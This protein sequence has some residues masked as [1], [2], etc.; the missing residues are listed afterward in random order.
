MLPR[1]LLKEHAILIAW[2]AKLVDLILFL[3][4][5]VLAYY[6]KFQHLYL[7]YFY[8]ITLLFATILIIPVFS[9]FGI[10]QPLRGRSLVKHFVTLYGAIVSVMLLLVAFMFITKTTIE[11]SR[12]WFC[13]WIINVVVLLSIF[14]LCLRF[15]LHKMRSYGWNQKRVLIIGAGEIGQNLIE[16]TKNALW[17]GFKVI[18]T[19]DDIPTKFK[20]YLDALNIDEIWLT[21]PLTA[22]KKIKNIITNL[23]DSMVHIRYFPNLVDLN[24]LDYS[25][26]EIFGFSVL[27][28][29]S[30]PMIGINRLVK[31]LED[32]ILALVIL[33]LTSPL[34]LITVCLVKLSSKGPIFYRQERMSWN[35]TNFNMLKFRSMPINSETKSGAVWAHKADN[36][37]TSIGAFLR[38]TSLDEL[39][40]FINVLRG[41]MSIV[42]P[43]PERPVFVE[44]FK[45]QIPNYMKKHLV[46]AGITGWAQ[47]NG[48]RGDTSLE[49]RIEHDLYYIENWSLWFDLK[50]ILLT[51]FK[52]FTNENA[53]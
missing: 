52:G 24:L 53:Y 23:Q 26:T 2:I 10:Y 50:I 9:L 18:E 15:I 28:I 41:E 48:W 4:A 51:V 33:L 11:F 46:K 1:G 44:Q 22:E 5:G 37:A 8:L 45:H 47:I 32:R 17:S 6:F 43:R 19:V 34:L 31:A 7:G 13:A 42:G 3:I 27:N 36:R 14:R 39:P 12:I 29:T 30:S 40:Q 20:E 35:G 21:W 49:K 16:H 38:K 25:T